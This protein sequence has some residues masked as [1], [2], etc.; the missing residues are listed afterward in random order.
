M[1]DG[2]YPTQLA[3]PWVVPS[4]WHNA[5]FPPVLGVVSR[6]LLPNKHDRRRVPFHASSSNLR[7]ENNLIYAP[8]ANGCFG[9]CENSSKLVDNES[10]SVWDVPR[11]SNHNE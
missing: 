8:A 7:L 9:S 2:T 10:I 1:H 5:G 4:K 3:G 6:H 11:H